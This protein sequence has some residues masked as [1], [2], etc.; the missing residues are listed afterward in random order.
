MT[1]VRSVVVARSGS[2]H[3]GHD[4]TSDGAHRPPDTGGATEAS[5]PRRT[6]VVAPRPSRARA[7]DS[8]QH[9][10]QWWRSGTG[11]WVAAREPRESRRSVR[12]WCAHATHHLGPLRLK[13]DD[14]RS[15]SREPGC[16]GAAVP[17][18][19]LLE[20]RHPGRVR[21]RP[22]ARRRS[23]RSTNATRSWRRRRSSRVPG[24]GPGVGLVAR[25]ASRACAASSLLVD[26]DRPRLRRG[27]SAPRQR[28]PHR[29]A[30]RARGATPRRLPTPTTT[31]GSRALSRVRTA[32]TSTS[33]LVAHS[34]RVVT[35]ASALWSP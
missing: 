25:V 5:Q 18:P 28:G 9:R 15:P 19:S 26:R 33:P 17:A 31:P 14:R 29:R 3:R 21:R 20:A 7:R 4:E 35:I 27:H 2:C 6:R 1:A 23:R 13:D 22:G 34:R 8:P 24:S 11:C 16:R 12:S 10:C 32:T 30:A